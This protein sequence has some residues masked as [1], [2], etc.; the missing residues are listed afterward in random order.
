MTQSNFVFD[1]S[2]YESSG[3][4]RVSSGRLEYNCF[5]E[6]HDFLSRLAVLENFLIGKVLDLVQTKKMLKFVTQRLG[7]SGSIGRPFSVFRPFGLK[8]LKLFTRECRRLIMDFVLEPCIVSS[9]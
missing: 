2:L 3:L 9:V 1:H 8:Q 4:V 5:S 6:D 7:N